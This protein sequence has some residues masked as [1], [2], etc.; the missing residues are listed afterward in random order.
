M[1]CCKCGRIRN[2]NRQIYPGSMFCRCGGIFVAPQPKKKHEPDD[3]VVIAYRKQFEHYI[4]EEEGK[5]SPWNRWQGTIYT[6]HVVE[7]TTKAI[8]LRFKKDEEPKWIP[9]SVMDLEF[10]GDSQ[11]EVWIPDWL[12]AVPNE[13]IV[14]FLE[15]A[16]SWHV[17]DSWLP[18]SL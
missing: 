2:R 5:P 8:R 9:K 14:E 18:K 11:V 3:P 12:M 16:E 4:Q 17:P 7:E 1:E 13:K 15:S 10:L 6:G